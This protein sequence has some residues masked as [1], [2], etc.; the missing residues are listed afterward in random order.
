MTPI[1]ESFLFSLCSSGKKGEGIITSLI[2][3]K[4]K[5]VLQSVSQTFLSAL[6]SLQEEKATI[7]SCK[8]PKTTERSQEQINGA[9]SKFHSI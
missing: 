3:F 9:Q 6:K 7:W 8:K 5:I 1:P 4:T 2:T